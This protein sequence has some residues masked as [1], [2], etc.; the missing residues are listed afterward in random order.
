[1]KMIYRNKYEMIDNSISNIGARK[2]ENIQNNIFVV[3]SIIHALLSKKSKEPVDIMVL[4]YKQM[5]DL[6]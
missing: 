3:N 2:K 5:F 4:D 1:M 6:G